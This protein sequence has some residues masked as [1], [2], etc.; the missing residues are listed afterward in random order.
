[1]KKESTVDR[2][3]SRRA[4]TRVEICPDGAVLVSGPFE[5][6]TGSDETPARFERARLCR[7]GRSNRKPFCDASHSA[8][9]FDDPGAFT[10]AVFETRGPIEGDGKV[11]IKSIEKGPL[12]IEGPVVIVDALGEERYSPG[13]FMLCRCG[14]SNAKP[15]CDG[16]HGEIDFCDGEPGA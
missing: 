10:S 13:R 1:M 4:P 7:C 16:R 14:E 8:C 15:F 2:E 5:L 12:L 3:S 11:V 9:S 6:L